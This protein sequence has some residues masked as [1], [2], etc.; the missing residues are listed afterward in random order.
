MSAKAKEAFP[1]LKRNQHVFKIVTL[2]VV[3]KFNFQLMRKLKEKE[4]FN[5]QLRKEFKEESKLETYSQA[6]ESSGKQRK[7]TNIDKLMQGQNYVS[8]M[9]Q[10]ILNSNRFKRRANSP[11]KQNPCHFNHGERNVKNCL[12]CEGKQKP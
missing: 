4:R 11:N 6:T 1:I 8:E 12:V 10:N 5:E 2:Y 9:K 7:D 3:D